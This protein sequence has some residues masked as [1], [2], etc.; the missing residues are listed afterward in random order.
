VDG[1]GSRRVFPEMLERA[2][3]VVDGAIVATL[4]QIAAAMRLIAERGR[5]VA[6]GA[7]ACSLAAALSG[8]A[9]KGKVVCIVSGGNIDREVFERLLRDERPA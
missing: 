7:G 8:G 2:R 3:S 5:V 1:I 9:G 4:A 6:E